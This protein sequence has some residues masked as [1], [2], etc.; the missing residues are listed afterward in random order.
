MKMNENNLEKFIKKQVSVYVRYGFK[1]KVGETHSYNGI[2]MGFDEL[3]IIINRKIGEQ[4]N[5][6]V[7][8]FFPWHNID[9]IRC[10][11]LK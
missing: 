11:K 10:N 9:A 7:N 2:L 5:T 1:K 4:L 8:D 6:E 3:G